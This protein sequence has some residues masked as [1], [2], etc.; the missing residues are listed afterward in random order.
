MLEALTSQEHSPLWS[1]T[2]QKLKMYCKIIAKLLQFFF[3][4]CHTDIHPFN[5]L[6]LLAY[7][8]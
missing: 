6:A 1:G 3:Q 8:D 7:L 2:K 5:P 4:S